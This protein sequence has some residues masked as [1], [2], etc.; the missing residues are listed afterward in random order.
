MFDSNT[1]NESYFLEIRI[2]RIEIYSIYDL[3][4]C[5][6]FVFDKHWVYTSVVDHSDLSENILDFI[7]HI[8]QNLQYYKFQTT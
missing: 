5:F 4:L 3:L 6:F 7:D 2:G 1:A 8:D